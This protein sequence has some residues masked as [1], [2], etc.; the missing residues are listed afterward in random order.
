M[1]RR[2]DVLWAISLAAATNVL[3][4][5]ADTI[6]TL[7]VGEGRNRHPAEWLVV[8]GTLMVV[9]VVWRVHCLTHPEQA[10][11]AHATDT[12]AV[13]SAPVTS[14]PVT[15][16][17][18]TPDPAAA[19]PGDADRRD[20][21]DS[22]DIAGSARGDAAAADTPEE[23][24]GP[25]QGDGDTADTGGDT[26]GTGDPGDPRAGDADEVA[27]VFPIRRQRRPA[28]RSG[29]GSKV[30]RMRE[31]WERQ[32]AAGRLPTGAEL[33]EAAGVTSS[34]GR[35]KRTAWLAELSTELREQ[36]E[37]ETERRASSQ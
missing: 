20:E 17:P 27:E 29:S 2:R 16:G 6:P 12:D 31:H 14:A 13:T 11:P 35:Q 32:I 30:G 1:R 4:H 15:S 22:G 7:M 36:L 34:L 21:G 23:G 25:G 3:A 19:V 5:L 24:G 28:G 33:N 8:A 26:A 37:R 18:V 9:L 10:D